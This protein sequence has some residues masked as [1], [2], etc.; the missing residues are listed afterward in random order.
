VRQIESCQSIIDTLVCQA[1]E[2]W[3]GLKKHFVEVGD[4]VEVRDTQVL[5][6]PSMRSL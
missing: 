3:E 1:V 2:H 5:E 4:A 6:V